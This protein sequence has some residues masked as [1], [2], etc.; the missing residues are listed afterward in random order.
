MPTPSKLKQLSFY[1]VQPGWDYVAMP[2]PAH[3][4]LCHWCQ[5]TIC[6]PWQNV[7]V[8]CYR[9]K[10]IICDECADDLERTQGI[11]VCHSCKAFASCRYLN[12]REWLLANGWA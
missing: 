1:A 9:D 12:D 8:W 3:G 2:Q 5:R 6:T 10:R 4:W 7:L 11:R